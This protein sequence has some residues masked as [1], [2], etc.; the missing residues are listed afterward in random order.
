MPWF[1]NILGCKLTQML[2]IFPDFTLYILLK[3]CTQHMAPLLVWVYQKC[4]GSFFK[5]TYFQCIIISR[6]KM[7]AIHLCVICAFWL[8][9]VKWFNRRWR[10]WGMDNTMTT[11]SRQ[12]LTRMAYWNSQL[13]AEL[14][15]C[16]LTSIKEIEIIEILS[17]EI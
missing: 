16:I 11:Y 1:H 14:K 9:L 10:V 7:R 17:F 8:K 12:I 6:E 5:T 4:T 13:S 3:N 15:K 2:T